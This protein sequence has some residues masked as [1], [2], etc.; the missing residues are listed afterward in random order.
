MKDRGRAE[1]YL[2]DINYSILDGTTNPD[3]CETEPVHVPGCVLPHG[4]LLVVEE[5][6]LRPLQV[7][8]NCAELGFPEPESVLS[9]ELDALF[10]PD[11]PSIAAS[12]RQEALGTSSLWLGTVRTASQQELE[13]VVHAVAG[14]VYLEFEPTVPPIGRLEQR[15]RLL[16][17]ELDLVDDSI[18]FCSRL[19]GGLQS[20]T[21]LS[22]V[23]I[24][25]FGADWS[26]EVIAEAVGE[27]DLVRFLG[28]RF[29]PMDIPKP[30]RDIY[31]KI[32]MRALP[33]ATL[34]PRA[35]VPRLNPL[36]GEPLDMSYCVL[37]GASEMYTEYLENMGVIA[38]V[39]A[40]LKRRG[41]LWGLIACHHSHELH[42]SPQTKA[43]FELLSQVASLQLENML[44]REN[45]RLAL[46]RNDSSQQ[47]S[48]LLLQESYREQDL[49]RLMNVLLDAQGVSRYEGGRLLGTGL[50][51][52]LS[53][54]EPLV[55]HIRALAPG[56]SESIFETHNLLSDYPPCQEW[57]V[58][59]GGLVCLGLTKDFS[60]CLI[61][62]REETVKHLKWGGN[63]DDK[64]VRYGKHGPRL[65]PR[66][67]F[68]T[69]IETVSDQCESWTEKELYLVRRL[70]EQFQE[71]L[72]R[73]AQDLATLNKQLLQANEELNAFAAIASHDLK[74]PLRGMANYATFLIED[75]GDR[76]ENEGRHMLERMRYL[77]DRMN[78]L[79]DALLEYSRLHLKE[80]KKVHRPLGDLVE[81][82]LEN[83]AG[84]IRDRQA[85][86]VVQEDL[87]TIFGYPPFIEG[88]LTNLLS[89]ALK[90]TSNDPLIEIKAWKE[91]DGRTTLSVKD[92]GI[93]IPEDKMNVIFDILVRLHH[94]NGDFHEGTGLGLTIVKKMTERHGGDVRVNSKVG[95]GSE[96][97]VTL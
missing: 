37:R 69:Y 83:L 51:P 44:T 74:E 56:L 18:E 73:R 7:S 2:P 5:K 61:W 11:G 21:G 58:K 3:N 35:L 59:P 17:N 86:I 23:M 79:L 80:I 92:N 15:L 71:K 81:H 42:L 41:Q 64:V 16:M 39:T 12:L 30:A 29:P 19:A 36:T 45:E 10:C 88:I 82:A 14:L 4:V 48:D 54:W 24:Y 32:N 9:S 52:S 6:T 27:E 77:A 33:N 66:A 87:P 84:R 67:S 22:R 57:S 90:Y 13:L 34:P 49:F 31:N 76:V 70:L 53:E 60:D 96:F 20:L 93:G 78:S 65:H 85:K 50:K 68:E 97:L 46:E 72:R 40:S 28:H 75:Y 91:E 25:R 26:G 43:A 47:L 63:P 38:S 8:D 89:N 95:E 55:S 94:R 1:H 62:F